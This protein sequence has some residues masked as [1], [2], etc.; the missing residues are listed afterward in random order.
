MNNRAKLLADALMEANRKAEQERADKQQIERIAKDVQARIA[1]HKAES[2]REITCPHCNE[3][4]TVSYRTDD[5]TSDSDS[6]D[7]PDNEQDNGAEVAD[8]DNRKLT[9]LQRALKSRGIDPF[10]ED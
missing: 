3:K 4:F 5:V 1:E 2:N 9:P 7:D 10:A 8:Y 6:N